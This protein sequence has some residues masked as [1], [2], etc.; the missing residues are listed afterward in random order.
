M[1]RAIRREL[2]DI[3]IS[4]AAFDANKEFIMEWFRTA[5]INGFF[6]EQPQP[7]DQEFGKGRGGKA[8]N[9]E[10]SPAPVDERPI[11]ENPGITVEKASNIMAFFRR[12]RK[13]KVSL[14]ANPV[15]VHHVDYDNK[16]REFTVSHTLP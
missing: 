1:W 9:S 12:R 5:I 15:H 13:L 2:D 4:V 3:G 16:Q 8:R 11:G 14:P 10:S 7:G 6:D